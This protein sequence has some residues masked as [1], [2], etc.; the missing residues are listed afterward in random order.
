MLRLGLGSHILGGAHQGFQI[1]GDLIGNRCGG[2]CLGLVCLAVKVV[3]SGSGGLGGRGGA[4]GGLDPF[5]S[6]DAGA[7]LLLDLFD[8]GSG[9]AL[10]FLDPGVFLGNQGIGIL[11]PFR[12]GG[13]GVTECTWLLPL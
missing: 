12:C 4:V 5:Q 11:G 8:L 2:V 1:R 7:Q 10:G 9:G 6:L 3:N 13:V